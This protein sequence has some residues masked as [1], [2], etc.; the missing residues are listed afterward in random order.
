MNFLSVSF[1]A[2]IVV[3][4]AIY[5]LVP[6][7]YKYLVITTGSYVF[8]GFT[9]LKMLIVLF[10]I[11]LITYIGGLLLESR[12][13]KALYAAFF[14]CTLLIL[15]VFKYTNFIIENVNLA[16][17]LAH[18]SPI[19]QRTILLPVGL[20]FIVFQACTY[21]GD[22]YKNNIGAERNFIR[23]A[24]FVAFFPTVLSGPIQKARNLLPQIKMPKSF[25][26]EDAKKGTIVFV[27][28]L[29]E[30]IMVA[31]KL[32]VVVNRVFTD[33]RHYNSAWFIIAAIC[34]SIYI[35]ADF[36]SY[37]DMARG[38][39]MIMGIS[40]GKNFENPYLSQSTSEFW[41]RWHVSLNTWFI[42][43]IYI[44]LGGNRR[45]LLRKYI[46][47]FI[48]FLVS[49]LWHGAS[50]HFVIWG[51][52]NGTFV[53]IGQV[54]KPVKSKIY[55]KLNV[56]ESAES[57]VFCK[58]VIVF[59]LITFTW[60]FFNNDVP[61][62]LFIA[63]RMLLFTPLYFFDQTLLSISG[64]AAGTFIT[65]VSTIVFIAV[66]KRRQFETQEY[67]KYSKQP[68]FFQTLL[69]AGLICICIFGACSTDAVVDKQFLYFQF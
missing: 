47:I 65:I 59:L 64:S 2:F 68:L 8:Y 55:K 44:P 54:V 4:F 61:A 50:Y 49:G 34:F 57:I 52:I 33:Y 63:K 35:Y 39:S 40:I 66:Q 62:S 21:L 41:K 9:S 32:L 14:I 12:K 60:L 51:I 15:I 67:E 18:V 26:S 13:V 20:S 38:V 42:E 46:N 6:Q 48:V 58:R 10:V 56:D 25:D 53:I 1:Y 11:T 37:S 27:W 5:F 69:M 29:F 30:K 23:Y 16:L 19:S 31:N 24:A 17:R 22:V 3:F 36:S 43:Y 28:G 7:K 45:G